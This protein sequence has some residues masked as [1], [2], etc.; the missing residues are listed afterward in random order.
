[1]LALPQDYQYHY[2]VRTYRVIDGD[3]IWTQLILGLDAYTEQYCRLIGL[4]TPE[5]WT[6]AGKLVKQVVQKWCTLSE[7]LQVVS[8]QRDKYAS[9]YDGIVW[10]STNDDS[11][12]DYLIRHEI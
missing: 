5:Q 8:V 3:T 4:D 9:R 12:N 7:P 1:M 10:N 11:L 2:A 6:D